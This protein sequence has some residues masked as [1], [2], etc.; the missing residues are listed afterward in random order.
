[1][2][3]TG[4]LPASFSCSLGEQVSQAL[5]LRRRRQALPGWQERILGR[6]QTSGRSDDNEE[7]IVARFSTFVSQSLPVGMPRQIKTPYLDLNAC[8]V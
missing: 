2:V 8:L 1:M 5:A 6:A 4:F 3:S 7:A